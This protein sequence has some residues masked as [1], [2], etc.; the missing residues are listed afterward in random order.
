M[1]GAT[2]IFKSRRRRKNREQQQV[3]ETQNKPKVQ[4]Q[5]IPAIN[6][7][8]RELE[9]ELERNIAMVKL[10]RKEDYERKLHKMAYDFKAMGAS[11]SI[12]EIKTKRKSDKIEKKLK[13]ITPKKI[14]IPFINEKIEK[15]QN[16]SDIILGKKS[17][18]EQRDAKRRDIMKKTGGKGLSIKIATPN[19][20]L[21]NIIC[22][23]SK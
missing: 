2:R 18:C 14:K 11:F 13:P 8:H 5:D 15:V 10:R 16:F 22:K 3:K 20:I 23:R 21:K 12:N 7:K 17:I 6:I 4:K 19:Q 1:L 9:R